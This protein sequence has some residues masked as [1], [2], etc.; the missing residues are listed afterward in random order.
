MSCTARVSAL[1]PSCRQHPAFCQPSSPNFPAFD[2]GFPLS[3]TQTCQFTCL[4]QLPAGSPTYDNRNL[5]DAS[6]RT[7]PPNP[8]RE[9]SRSDIVPVGGCRVGGGAAGW[10]DGDRGEHR[11]LLPTPSLRPPR[12]QPR[13]FLMQNEV[14][15]VAG[16]GACVGAGP[17]Q[18]QMPVSVRCAATA[19]RRHVATRALPAAVVATP[20][21]SATSSAPPARRALHQVYIGRL[22]MVGECSRPWPLAP[23]ATSLRV[24]GEGRRAFC[25]AQPDP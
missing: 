19:R 8:V 21:A 18:R 16:Q 23:A 24:M 6:K 5:Y 25:R 9:A 10:A 14:G 3:T 2:S 15:G 11:H 12:L 20:P 7:S 13:R 4:H 1:A 22:A 17:V